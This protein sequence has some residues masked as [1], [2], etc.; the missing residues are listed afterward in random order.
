MNDISLLQ[1]FF[2]LTG[3]AVIIITILLVIGLIYIISFV[4]TV[5]KVAQTAHKV[6]EGISGD[7]QDL[8][9]NIHERGFSLGALMSF[10]T[11]LGKKSIK[12]KK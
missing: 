10:L 4:R 11:S 3:T 6:T 7:I 12:R 9:E 5:R 1:V 8:R 2:Y